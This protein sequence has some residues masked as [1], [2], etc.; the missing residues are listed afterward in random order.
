MLEWRDLIQLLQALCWN[1][2]TLFYL[3]KNIFYVQKK[4]GSDAPPFRE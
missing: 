1:D 3:F 2:V 4:R